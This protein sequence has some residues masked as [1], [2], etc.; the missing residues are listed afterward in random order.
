[1]DVNRTDDFFISSLTFGELLELL[2]RDR[3]GLNYII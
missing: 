2:E 1:M 3:I